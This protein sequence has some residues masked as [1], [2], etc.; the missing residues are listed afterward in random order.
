MKTD[1]FLR[2]LHEQ[3]C[4]WFGLDRE[5]GQDEGRLPDFWDSVSRK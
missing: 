5:I 1:R 4:C 3:K 2:M